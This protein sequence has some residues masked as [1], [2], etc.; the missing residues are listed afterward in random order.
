MYNIPY[1]TT[2]AGAMAMAQA[3]WEFKKNGL[4]VKSLQE[5]YA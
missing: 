1:A 2:V 5:Y 3:I 4:H